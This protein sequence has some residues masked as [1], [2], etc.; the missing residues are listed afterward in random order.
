MGPPRNAAWLSLTRRRARICGGAPT[1][2]MHAHGHAHGLC[3]LR[4]C[5]PL[6]RY[7]CT[8]SRR[9]KDSCAHLTPRNLLG[10]R[11]RWAG[12][13][14]VHGGT[15]RRIREPISRSTRAM[16]GGGWWGLLPDTGCLR[17]PS[18]H[19]CGSELLRLLE[20]RIKLRLPFA[21]FF[22]A[23][24]LQRRARIRARLTLAFVL[25]GLCRSG[26]PL[27]CPRDRAVAVDA[28]RVEVLLSRNRRRTP[29]TS[30]RAAREFLRP[31]HFL[32][33]Q[34]GLSLEQR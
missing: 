26:S 33:W 16:R 27:W 6:R 9:T 2:A 28:E 31:T 30:R 8:T 21:R 3:F 10:R 11:P 18:Q 5:D 24:R 32:R 17:P 34:R 1:R 14:G 19:C 4:A 25:L 22:C 20:Q 7:G 23:R 13:N 29:E 15:Q 12:A